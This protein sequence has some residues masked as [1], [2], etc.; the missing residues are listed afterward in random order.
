MVFESLEFAEGIEVWVLVIE[1][2]DKANSDEWAVVQVVKKR[3][4]V[5]VVVQRPSDCVL[6][7]AGA[8]LCRINLPQLLDANAVRLKLLSV[9]QVELLYEAFAE[10]AVASLAKQCDLCVQLHAALKVSLR[11][12]ILGNANIVCGNSLDASIVI[13]NNLAGS[14]AWVDLNAKRLCLLA[15]PLDKVSE[16]HN[17]VSVVVQGHPGHNGDWVPRSRREKAKVVLC[18]GCVQRRPH[19]LP[20]GKEFIKR[21]GL[22]DGTRESVGANGCGLLQNAHAHFL[23]LRCRNLL[24]ADG[25]R[26]TGGTTTHNK[27]ISLIGRTLHRDALPTGVLFPRLHVRVCRDCGILCLFGSSSV[28]KSATECRPNEARAPPRNMTRQHLSRFPCVQLQI[29]ADYMD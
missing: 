21:V 2:N 4:A 6:N 14:I 9:A 24:D 3:T 29:E 16:P 13:V 26:Q 23:V 18:D 27:Y 22:N 15:K 10:R 25:S 20:V 5:C 11:R 7:V 1:P 19:L 17:V 28:G 8:V 12:S